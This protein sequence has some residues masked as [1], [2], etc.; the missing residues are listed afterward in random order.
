MLTEALSLRKGVIFAPG[1]NLNAFYENFHDRCFSSRTL[2]QEVF[3]NEHTV[4]TPHKNRRNSSIL[5]R[6][7]VSAGAELR[8]EQFRILPRSWDNRT[9]RI[10]NQPLMRS[11]EF[12]D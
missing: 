2:H 5:P 6:D 1:G 4:A 10:V 3:E 12:A 8:C 9:A 11:P 7:P